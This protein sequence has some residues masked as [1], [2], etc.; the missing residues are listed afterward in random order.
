MRLME[1]ICDPATGNLSESKLWLHI[2][3]GCMVW[4]FIY[5]V[6]K[7]SD[8]EWLWLVFATVLTAHEAFSRLISWKYGVTNDSIEKINKD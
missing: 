4:A 3:K 1:F 8:T 7:D 2:A 5:N 6:L